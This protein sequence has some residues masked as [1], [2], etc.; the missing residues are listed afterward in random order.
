MLGDKHQSLNIARDIP[1]SDV[2][3]QEIVGVLDEKS[4]SSYRK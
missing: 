1:D 2:I 3:A 4:A